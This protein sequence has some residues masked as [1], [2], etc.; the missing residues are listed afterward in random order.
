MCE[1][2][3]INK[4]QSVQEKRIQGR[5]IRITTPPPPIWQLYKKKS[6]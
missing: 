4:E 5:F 2:T 1:L 3:G 6:K